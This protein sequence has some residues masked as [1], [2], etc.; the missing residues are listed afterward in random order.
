MLCRCKMVP[1]K[2][3]CKPAG[4]PTIA[5]LWMR[6][7]FHIRAQCSSCNTHSS[8]QVL[9]WGICCKTAKIVFMLLNIIPSIYWFCLAMTRTA[10]LCIRTLLLSPCSCA[11][12]R[13]CIF[14]FFQPKSATCWSFNTKHLLDIY[15]LCMPSWVLRSRVAANNELLI[16]IYGNTC[17]VFLHIGL[18]RK[19]K[20]KDRFQ[21]DV[22]HS[23]R[24]T[25]LWNVLYLMWAEKGHVAVLF[26]VV[27]EMIVFSDCSE[28]Y[29]GG[30][31]DRVWHF[32]FFI[33]C[34]ISV[35]I[36]EITAVTQLDSDQ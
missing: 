17:N 32:F 23:L 30:N 27:V 7:S 12:A 24:R 19:W 2:S 1:N 16:S 29:V 34:K 28:N 15:S 20:G 14:F 8:H 13:P 33:S 35:F 31:G 11:R 26:Y 5:S 3:H 18:H 36:L 10:R 4:V 25:C 6:N 9:W 21:N 22:S